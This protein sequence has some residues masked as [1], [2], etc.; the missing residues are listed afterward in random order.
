[1]PIVNDPGPGYYT[2]V[3]MIPGNCLFRDTGAL[4]PDNKTLF[5]MSEDRGLCTRFRYHRHKLVL[6]LSAMRS[7]RDCLAE[8]SDLLYY[9]MEDAT[10]LSYEEKLFSVLEKCNVKSVVTYVFEDMDLEDRI[11]GLCRRTGVSLKTVESPG[12]MLTID[13]FRSYRGGRKKLL[14]N[15]FYIFQRKRLG[16][17]TDPQ[18][19]PAGGKWNLDKENRKRLPAFFPVPPVPSV[20]GSKHTGAVKRIVDGHFPS[21]PG[22]CSNFYL[23]TTR[24]EALVWLDDFAKQRLKDFG[25]YEDA[26][27]RSE[28]FLFHS[29]LS[30]L[31]NTGLLTPAE[32]LEKALEHYGRN[33][34][35]IPLSSIEGFVRQLIGWREFMRGMY[36]GPGLRGNFFGHHRKLG[37]K[38]Y[39][40]DLGIE[41]VDDVIRKV[42][43]YGYCHHI[44]RLMVIGNFMLLC[45]IHP[46]EVYRWFMEMFVDAYE[47]VMVPNVYGMSQFADG[48]TLSTWPYISG[49]GYILRMSDYKR[50]EWCD[51]WD[52]L[53]WRFVDRKRDILQKNFRMGMM[54]SAYD[55]MDAER[56]RKMSLLAEDFLATLQP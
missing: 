26:L 33:R 9:G 55:R 19:R 28:P 24:E 39:E 31:L 13:E 14:M 42:L 49:S 44:E 7:Y 10:H 52:A 2:K 21:N 8:N 11:R 38:W 29:V 6:I 32:V 48:G 25:P 36:H 16:Y 4:E 56:K 20:P 40:G 30:P 17:L 41:P 23:P 27:K 46:D 47:W 53:Y 5:F 12:F 34:D 3:A 45:E 54:V 43:E 50:G 37:W 18:G 22:K 35:V 51:I 1:M 15:N